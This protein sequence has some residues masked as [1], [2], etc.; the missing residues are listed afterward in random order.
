[1]LDK[2]DKQLLG[3]SMVPKHT[4]KIMRIED[5]NSII[6][7]RLFE[8]MFDEEVKGL[9]GSSVNYKEYREFHSKRRLDKVTKTIWLVVMVIVVMMVLL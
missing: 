9:I 5:L 3:Y 7:Q 2:V 4:R 6:Q 8:P 1:M